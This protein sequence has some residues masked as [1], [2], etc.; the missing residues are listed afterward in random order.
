ML[1]LT[2]YIEAYLK[3]WERINDLE[4]Y[5]WVAFKHYKENSVMEFHSFYERINTVYGKSKNLLAA[6]HY[7]PLGVLLDIS[8]K[9]GKPAELKSLFNTLLQDGVLPTKDRVKN[10]ISGTRSLMNIMAEG[11]FSDWKGRTNLQTFQDPHS[12]SVYLSMFYPND[13]FIYKYGI[14]VEFAKITQYKLVHRDAIDRLFE[15]QILCKEVKSQLQK[16]K[17][18]I[19]FYKEWLKVHDFVDDNLNLLTQDFIYAIARHMNSDAFS[20]IERKKKRVRQ[21]NEIL[22]GKLESVA[23][24]SKTHSYT[25]SKGI[26]YKKIEQ[27]NEK[28]GFTG[29]MWVVNFEKERLKELGISPDKVRHTSY[30]DGDGCGYDILS[31]EDDGLTPRYI[32][33]KTTSGKENQPI[34]FSDNEL[35]FSI[36]H[37][38]HYCLYRLYNFKAPNKPADLT[39]IHDSLDALTAVP[40]TFRATI[41]Y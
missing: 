18:L 8:S 34:F 16:N 5:K 27:Q 30:L 39:I 2:S 17:E 7:Y 35:N 33:V 1:D 22:A 15:Y 13:F 26:E 25:C 28:L 6:S 32:E 3:D 12:V 23:P 21:F 24:K 36:E 11:G 40:I 9:D 29:E 38:E 19:N 31:V 20:E 41:E 10:F 4:F 14:F 37:K